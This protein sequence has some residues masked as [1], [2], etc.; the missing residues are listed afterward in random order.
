MIAGVLVSFVAGLV[1]AFRVSPNR[2]FNH[3]DL[4][5][6]IEIVALYLFYRGGVLLVD[7]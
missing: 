7:R 5:H 3:N 6:V 4:Y 2:W 1:Q